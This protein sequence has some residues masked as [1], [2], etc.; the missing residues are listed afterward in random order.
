MPI[1]RAQPQSVSAN[2]ANVDTRSHAL[3]PSLAQFDAKQRKIDI[4]IKSHN[5]ST[6]HWT[7]G[8]PA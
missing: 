7:D 2:G 5:V 3:K 8:L 1:R 4:T 6:A